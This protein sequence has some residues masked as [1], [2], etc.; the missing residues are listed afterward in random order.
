[1]YWAYLFKSLGG[2][3]GGPEAPESVEVELEGLMCVSD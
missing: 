2:G 1:M 3:Y